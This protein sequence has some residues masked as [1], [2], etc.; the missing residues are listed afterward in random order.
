MTSKE[1]PDVDSECILDFI[2]ARG[3]TFLGLPRLDY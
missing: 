1:K 2:C 3:I